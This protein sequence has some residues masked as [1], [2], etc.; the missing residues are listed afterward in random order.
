MIGRGC[1]PFCL[2]KI[3]YRKIP[4]FCNNCIEI[5][6]LSIILSLLFW[7]L[8]PISFPFK[9]SFS[10]III[11]TKKT[12]KIFATKVDGGKPLKDIEKTE[13]FV[14]IMGSEGSGVSKELL[15]AADEYLYIPMNKKCES[16]NASVA[17]SIIMY[18]VSKRDYEWLCFNRKNS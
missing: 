18:E 14:I 17:A 13:K 1:I 3:G 8:F 11:K 9:I 4:I 15:E 7:L 12:H 6:S 5:S 16:L 10:C 2:L